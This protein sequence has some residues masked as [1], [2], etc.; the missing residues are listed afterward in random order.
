[1]AAIKYDVGVIII[2]YN[3]S[4]L[5][6][7]A[8]KSIIEHTNSSL[9]YKIIV[10]DNA[11]SKEDYTA[12]KDG[13]EKLGHNHV[14]LLRSM[15]NTGFGGGNMMGVQ[16]VNAHYYA[17]INNDTI[18]LN[19]CLST[20]KVYLDQN[21]NVA[22]AG[23]ELQ[24]E[25]NNIQVGFDHFT[26]LQRE[27]LGKATLEFLN[28]KKYPARRKQYNSPLPVSFVN[29]S[30]MFVRASDFNSVGGFDTNIFL[31]YEEDDLCYRLLKLGKETHFIPQA[32]Y[33]H[34]Q[35]KSMP[36]PM[37]Q[38]LELKTSLFYVTRK[39][40][41]YL[42]YQALRLFYFIRYT[43]TCIVKP[44]YLPL[45]YRILIGMPL[46]KSLKHQQKIIEDD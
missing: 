14:E 13:L 43:L 32:K 26:S 34:Y 2:N 39:H 6:I 18:L 8:V 10:V 36:A 1:M 40:Q 9:D 23:P 12:L 28:P 27:I 17:F 35:G 4:A 16:H 38:K 41:G 5:S 37:A 45:L 25:N 20:L 19:D 22:V 7:E 21:A 31:F 15:V 29:G 30:F 3:N 33:I 24:D 44:K 11:S 42:A 46:T